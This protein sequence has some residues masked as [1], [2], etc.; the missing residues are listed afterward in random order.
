[1][2]KT[3]SEYMHYIDT[4]GGHHEEIK[5]AE[6]RKGSIHI[7]YTYIY[8]ITHTHMHHVPSLA[9]AD[10]RREEAFTSPHSSSIL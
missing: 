6:E 2:Q 5:P 10:S 4:V 3:P 9:T 8:N 1:M 7:I